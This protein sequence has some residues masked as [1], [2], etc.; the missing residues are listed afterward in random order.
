MSMIMIFSLILLCIRKTNIFTYRMEDTVDTLQRLLVFHIDTVIRLI[1]VLQGTA[2]SN[3]F[4]C[5]ENY[6]VL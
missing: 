6:T 1:V 2:A 3:I 4:T 5:S